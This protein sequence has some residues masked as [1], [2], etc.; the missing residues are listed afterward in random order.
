[1]LRNLIAFAVALTW[2]AVAPGQGFTDIEAGLTGLHFSDAAWGDYDGD[3]DLDLLI[4]GLDSSENGVTRLYR[5]E[6]DDQ[7][8]AVEGLPFP[9]TFV[10]DFCW[11]DYDN[12]GDLDLLIQGYTN[13]TEITAIY[14]NLGGDE[15]IESD[16]ELP[17]LTDGSVSFADF[18][19]DGY[20]DLLLAGFDGD[21]NV[22][23]LYENEGDATFSET[24]I[25]L[26]GAIKSCYEW[27]DYDNDGDLDIF[28][29]GL[30]GNGNL[31]SV[32]YQNEDGWTFNA[33]DNEFTGV[34]LGDAAWGDYDSDG[35]LDLL[36]S[37]FAFPADSIAE[38]YRN[39]G[40]G[41]FT[42]HADTGLIGVSHSSTIWG[43][44][45]ND[46]DLDIFLSGTYE[47]GG[48][49]VRVTDVFINN[50]INFE[51]ADLTFSADVFWGES[52]WGDYDCDRDLDLVCCGYDDLGGSNTIIYRN[53]A[54]AANTPPAPPPWLDVWGNVFDATLEWGEA[55]DAETADTSLTYNLYIRNEWGETIL[56]PMSIVPT[57]Q[58]L[59]PAWGNVQQNRSWLFEPLEG[60]YYYWSVQA[61]DNNFAGSVFAPED[62][63]YVGCIN[64]DPVKPSELRLLT[65]YPNPFNGATLFTYQL[66][67]PGAV[68]L[69]IYDLAGRLVKTPVAEQQAAGCHEVTWRG[70]DAAGRTIG[71]GLYP[72]RLLLDGSEIAAGSCLLVK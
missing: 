22:A 23:F 70:D 71:S 51:A 11:G 54:T 65:N 28:I 6:G 21:G 52:A 66:S 44:Y 8:S 31:I 62:T 18:N 27:G 72:Y 19:N 36:L 58:R 12:D 13:S 43:D 10:G 69:E 38:L 60:G 17:V 55:S 61:V 59:L 63:F 32:L 30:D 48:G 57:G 35:D 29:N 7:F 2:T 3:G 20:P 4:A 15:F 67:R 34:W 47:E 24:G 41:T 1:M 46:G 40:D 16:V 45:D 49:W 37:G 42:Q 53:E 26:P 5:N 9:G 25:Q 39:N 68:R 33:T 64:V 14:E 50:G 56:S